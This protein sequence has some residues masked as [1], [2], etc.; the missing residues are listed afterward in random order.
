MYETSSSNLLADLTGGVLRLQLNRPE[1]SNA[2]NYE[3]VT[4]ALD[5][6]KKA[7]EDWDV[8]VVVL[9]GAG[10]D[11]CAGEAPEDMGEWPEAYAHRFHQG[12]HGPGPIPQQDLFKTL[13]SLSKPTVALMKGRT[14]DAGLDLAC[15]SDVRLA[16][17]DSVIADTRV[18]K[19]QHAVTGLAYILPRLIGQSQAMRLLLT[20]EEISGKEAE[21]IGLVYGSFS[22][23]EYKEKSEE[24][25]NEL[26]AMPTR[27]YALIKQQILNQ[28]D[29]PY[30]TAL[31][32]SLAV[33]QT[34]V[35]E[36]TKEGMRAFREKRK[37]EYKGR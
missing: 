8:R 18:L 11:F 14:M 4:A 37:P 33:R 3:M 7:D 10:D 29:M 28:L 36:D 32:H 24:I 9:E 31:M 2:L 35:I 17:D 23:G 20:G 25:I 12:A 30:E 1:K 21:R 15:V 27:S 22:S 6:V 19:A 13:R 34:N 16:E 5:L 26:A